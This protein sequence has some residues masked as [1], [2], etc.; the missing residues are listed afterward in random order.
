M[1]VQRA[2]YLAM[3]A[4]VGVG[5]AAAKTTFQLSDDYTST[6]GTGLPGDY[7]SVDLINDGPEGARFVLQEIELRAENGV[8]CFGAA[9]GFDPNRPSRKSDV[10]VGNCTGDEPPLPGRAKAALKARAVIT[11]VRVCMNPAGDTVAA[12]EVAGHRLRPDGTLAEDEK[13]SAVHSP[14][15][16]IWKRWVRCEPG[17]IATGFELY[18]RYEDE[19]AQ[20]VT[21]LAL[22]CR[23]ITAV[24]GG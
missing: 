7:D 20:P 19:T 10:G 23:A 11:A 22:L 13:R 21:G 3:A 9:R 24:K 17:M 14:D 6:E 2:I 5:L 15:C 1:T 16:R 18:S 4:C 12:Y 8:L